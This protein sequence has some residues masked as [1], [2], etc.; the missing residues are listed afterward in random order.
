MNNPN[1]FVPKGSLL[2]Q[3][4]KTRSRVKL[5]VFCIVAMNVLG[6]MALLMEGCKREQEAP[7]APAVDTNVAPPMADTN[8]APMTPDTNLPPATPPTTP[9]TPPPPPPVV[10]PT[11]PTPPAGTEYVVVHG[12]T[13][14]KIAHKNGVTVK[15]LEDANPGVQPTKLKVGQKLSL[16]A[17]ATPAPSPTA[18]PGTTDMGNV[19]ELYTVKS[20]DTLTKIARAHGTTVKKIQAENN[21]TTTQIRVGQKLKLPAAAAA[22]PTA[23]PPETPATPMAPPVTTPPTPAPGPAGT[24]TGR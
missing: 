10:T 8:A 4:N 22:A 12:D 16:P 6:L 24:P 1:P 18:T 7:A 23:A 2:E 11:P 14:A 19:G 17:G 15:A 13:L 9:T 20:G 21:M 5:W 3:Q